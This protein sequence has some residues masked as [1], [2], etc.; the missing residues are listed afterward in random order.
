MKLKLDPGKYV[1]AVSGGVDSVVLLDML[2]RMNDERRTK[3]EEVA[4]SPFLLPP[5]PFTFI[6]AHFDHGIREDSADDQ[7]FVGDLAKQYG[8]PYIY[9]AGKLGP[10]TSE[11]AARKA[12]YD[13][14]HRVRTSHKAQAVITAHHEDDLLETALLNLARGTNRKGLSSLRSTETLKRPLLSYSKQQLIEYAKAHDLTWREDS[15]NADVKY[16]RN[17]IRQELMPKLSAE[18]RRKWLAILGQTQELNDTIDT[19]L[20]EQLEQQPQA[21]MLDRRW[22]IALPHKV[23][24]EVMATWLRR[25]G[26]TIDQPMLERLVISAK[27]RLPGKQ[28]DVSGSFM[29]KIAKYKLALTNRDR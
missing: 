14:L 28:V 21:T 6:V 17:R 24:R 13:F 16:L 1:V 5:S 20:G 18:E 8:L 23:A 10:K 15:T 12:R 19:L 2:V 9:E 29:L 3:N 26:V 25:Q 27:T 22:F 7:K 11:A 4:N